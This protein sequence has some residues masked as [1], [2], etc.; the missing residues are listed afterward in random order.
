M[1]PLP[2]TAALDTAAYA[3]AVAPV[4]ALPVRRAPR[5]QPRDADPM[6]SVTFE[7]DRERARR[8]V[9]LVVAL[10]G[11]VVTAPVMLV[12]AALIKVTSRGPVFYTQM[13][14]GLDR[15]DPKVRAVH[16]RRSQDHG[17]RPFKIY[18]FRTMRPADPR[19]TAQVWASQ[20]DPRI[21][22]LGRILRKYR[23]DEL[24]QLFNVLRGDMNIVGPRPEQ[25]T[26]F[27]DLRTKVHAYQVRQR[28]RP[29]ITGWAQINQHYD[30]S[31]DDVR[32]KVALDLEYIQRQSLAHDL[33]IMLSTVPVM[34]LRKG[35]W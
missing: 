11:I 8:V 3:T 20:N 18:K 29:G 24:P 15:R 21:T 33:R 31:L 19:T 7:G 14:I 4:R 6:L 10:L 23:I 26:I 1:T 34:V 28:V 16:P 5:T 27:A 12:V 13:R 25:P 35:A 32:R 9:N 30:A 22:A 2:S 17:G